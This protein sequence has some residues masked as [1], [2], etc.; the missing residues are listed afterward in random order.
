MLTKKKLYICDMC[1]TT[2]FFGRVSDI[3]RFILAIPRSALDIP[4]SS[5]LTFPFPFNPPTHLPTT[6]SFL[7]RYAERRTASVPVLLPDGLVVVGNPGRSSKR[8]VRRVIYIN[9]TLEV[10]LGWFQF[11]FAIYIKLQS[12]QHCLSCLL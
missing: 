5:L 2:C 9:Q 6:L 10:K 7:T 12:P 8:K 4:S 3:I 11:V 1:T